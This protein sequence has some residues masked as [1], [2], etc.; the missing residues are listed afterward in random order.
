MKINRNDAC[1]CGSEKKY[2]DCHGKQ[3][4]SESWKKILIYVGIAIVLIWFAMDLFSLNKSSIT[5]APPGKVW[6]EEHGHW[7]DIPK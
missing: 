5:S 4:Q 1:H 6:S 3:V 7:H 2:K